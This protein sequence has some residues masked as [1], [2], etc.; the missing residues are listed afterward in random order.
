MEAEQ[1]DDEALTGV[2]DLR[3]SFHLCSPPVLYLS[4]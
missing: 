1:I 2:K 4:G 3:G